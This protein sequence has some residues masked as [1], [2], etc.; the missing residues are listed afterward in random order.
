MDKIIIKDLEIFAYH[1]VLQHEK[2]NGQTF[3]VSAELYLDLR[4]AGLTDDLEK[5][6]NYAMVCDDI[7]RVM[8]E[9]KY[10]LIEAVAENIAST[11]LLKYDKIKNVHIIISKPEAPIDMS[12]DT[13][14]VDIIR[15]KHIAYLG[16]GS[17]LGDKEGYLDYAVDQL[18]K[19]EYIKV[20]KVSTYIVTK[21]YGDVEQDDFLNGCLEVETL[22]TPF[23]LLSVINDIEQG[24]GRKRLIHWGP[25]TLDIDVLL[26]DRDIIMEEKLKI[27]H[28]EMAKRDFVL[29][30]LVEIAPYAYHPGYNKT[31]ME[32]LDLLEDKTY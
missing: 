9:E 7:S 27:P 15:N 10:D 14:C 3:I 11:I 2:I 22:Y 16:I 32:L 1:G 13:V 5:T 17:N 26:Y 6:V 20:N 29:K 8:T 28:I 30:P 31:V 24:A 18:N 21:P 19:D 12:F 23:E 25:R 4:D